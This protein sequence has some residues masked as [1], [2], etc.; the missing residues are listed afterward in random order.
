MDAKLK[1]S[2]AI[3]KAACKY[4]FYGSCLMNLRILEDNS[5]PTFCTD[6]RSILWNRSFADTL[7][8]EETL[9]ILFHE[10][11]HVVLR[12]TTENI[13]KDRMLCTMAQDYVIN[14]T[15]REDGFICPKDGLYNREFTN[16]SWV[17]V[18]R[19]LK[20]IKAKEDQKNQSASVDGQGSQ[21]DENGQGSDENGQGSG[22]GE[23]EKEGSKGSNGSKPDKRDF[24]DYPG[25]GE[26]K[27]ND[28][29][30][31]NR[32]QEEIG[33]LTE[34]HSNRC[35]DISKLSEAEIEK[36]SQDVKIM[37]VRASKEQENYKPGS[38]PGALK[39]LIETIKESFVDWR[40][41]LRSRLKSKYPENYTF[42]RPNRKFLNQSGIYMPSMDSTT[43]KLL[44]IALDTSASVSDEE[45]IS[46]LSEVNSIS[47]ELLIEETL[48]LYADTNIAKVDKYLFGEEITYFD[49]KGGGGTDYKDVFKYVDKELYQEP[50]YLV[51]F[52]DM[53][54]GLDNFPKEIPNYPVIWVSTGK[55][56]NVPFGELVK[57][58][59]IDLK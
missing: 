43:I 52:S 48:V 23:E 37:A 2:R 7:D 3:V 22:E 27:A 15:L 42:S 26:N 18:Y 20:D 35:V 28:A 56:Y 58:V 34:T 41:V 59:D 31:S 57:C 13:D 54:V 5:Q 49:A 55:N 21:S 4:P 16:M 47:K 44:V 38:L 32:T 17:E 11:L 10:V 45:K 25:D 50:G 30:L 29:K 8:A 51:Y 12:H 53:E 39:D 6:G 40:V 46:Y 1:I 24:K 33:K 36:I 19:I 14:A 9:F